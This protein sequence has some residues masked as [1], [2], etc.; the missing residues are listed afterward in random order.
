MDRVGPVYQF[1][2]EDGR[3]KFDGPVGLL[4]GRGQFERLDESTAEESSATVK[5]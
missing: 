3:W 4:Q 1:V 2:Y 5:P